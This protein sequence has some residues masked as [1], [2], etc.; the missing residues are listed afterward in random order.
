MTPSG[1]EPAT[2]RLVAQCLNQPRHQ[3]RAP[4][5]N[6]IT[7]FL[8]LKC[9]PQFSNTYKELRFHVLFVRKTAVCRIFLPL[10]NCQCSIFSKKNLII[11]I[12]CI[13]GWLA[14]PIKPDKYSSAVQCK[15]LIHIPEF[16][17]SEGQSVASF[18]LRTRMC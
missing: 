12:F 7:S 5:C 14:V 17:A 3:Q 10:Q 4:Y 6:C 18:I 2:F 13:S 15:H 9:L 16:Y 8:R 1:I 11:R